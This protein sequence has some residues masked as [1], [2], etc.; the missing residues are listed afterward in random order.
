MRILRWIFGIPLAF[1]VV[2]AILYY[3][4]TYTDD[5]LFALRHGYLFLGVRSVEFI[6]IFAL[7]VF[8]SCLFVPRPK[9]I[10]A[11][12]TIGLMTFLESLAVFLEFSNILEGSVSPTFVDSLLSSFVGMSVGFVICFYAF[13]NRGWNRKAK[14]FDIEILET[15]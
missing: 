14:I 15:Y 9:K 5:H 2:I 8:L 10:A 6:I 3:L 12:I 13:K 4:V 7:L 1:A 11:L